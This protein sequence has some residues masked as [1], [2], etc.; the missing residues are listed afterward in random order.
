[1]PDPFAPLDWTE[2]GAPRSTTFGDIYFS[3]QDGLAESRAVFLQGCGLPREWAARS[4]FTVA[5]LGFGTGLNIAALLYLWSRTATSGARLHIFSVE[6]FPLRAED[7][8]R[9]LAAWP[10][11]GAAA[12]ALLSAWPSPARGFHRLDLPGFNATLDL[13]VME[14]E[15]ALRA[16]TGRADAW[17]LDGFAPASNPDMWTEA[18]MALVAQRSNP[19]ARAATFTV[20]GAV[21]RGLQA[22]G[23]EVDKQPGH[24]RK[25]ERLE[26]RLQGSP[27]SLRRPASVA[28]IGAGIAGASVARALRAQGVEPVLI[29][30]DS[31][32]ASGNPAALVAPGL[33]ASGRAAARLYAQAFARAVQLYRR[34]PVVIGE[35]VWR[36]PRSERDRQ[37]FAKV[38]AQDIFAPGA[39]EVGEAGALLI[40]DGLVVEPAALIERWLPTHRTTGAVTGLIRADSGWRIELAGAEALEAEGVVICAGWGS[41]ALVDA[42]L[43][44]IRGQVS[45]MIALE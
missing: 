5:E 42:G 38:A 44:P 40:R 9:A 37:R 29:A 11:L 39:I 28:V 14:A 18:V 32:A 2:T 8:K 15:P 7:A 21:R 16:W 3:S 45:H 24:G 26:A 35:G 36:R 20:A 41:A 27:T 1:M 6:A 4:D 33:D 10:E 34:E 12:E 25:R 23:F 13:A 30:D 17:F 22:A 43:S 19:G 31:Q